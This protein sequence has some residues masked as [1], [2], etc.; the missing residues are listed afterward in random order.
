M[1][2]Y[3]E[4]D[5][6]NAKLTNA[7]ESLKKISEAALSLAVITHR[8]WVEQDSSGEFVFKTASKRLRKAPLYSR[9]LEPSDF[10]M[11]AYYNVNNI[12]DYFPTGSNYYPNIRKGWAVEPGRSKFKQIS[13]NTVNLTKFIHSRLL[14]KIEEAI[15]VEEYNCR[16]IDFDDDTIRA[17]VILD[18]E[19]NIKETRLFNKNF[20]ND[21]THIEPNRRF[22]LRAQSSPGEI[23]F[24][25]VDVQI[26]NKVEKE[27]YNWQ[28]SEK[29]LKSK[30]FKQNRTTD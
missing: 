12:K 23:K 17:E 13:I 3:F 4:N 2:D 15:E 20:L 27:D 25:C 5:K 6:E 11:P 10:D 28:F 1:E 7:F 29:V 24:T 9:T 22:V 14:D 19:R 30:L 8:N 18:E 21:L 16:I 26:S